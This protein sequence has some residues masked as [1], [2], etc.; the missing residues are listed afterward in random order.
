MRYVMKQKLFSFTDDYHITNE[1]GTN[2]Y[3]VDGKLLSFGK[4]LSFQ[5]ME[6]KEL[7]H[8]QQKLLHWGPTYEITHDGELVA[9]VKKEL[10][11]FFH[12]VFHV[13]E[14]GHDSLT[15]EGNFSDHEY[16]F[17]RAG[18]PVASVSKQWFTFVDTYG[19]EV[20]GD[21]DPVLILAC[22][23]VIDEA[24]HGDQNRR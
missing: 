4:N 7:A 11:T 13:D 24:C 21:E 2:V 23:V 12:C 22:T 8:I 1:D 9:V 18:R 20:E 17:T 3:Y 15:A 5:D 10:F 16:V 19:V 14:P 6:Q